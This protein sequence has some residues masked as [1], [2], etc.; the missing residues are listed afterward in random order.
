MLMSV[1]VGSD[2]HEYPDP[3]V[4]LPSLATPTNKKTNSAQRCMGKRRSREEQRGS[5]MPD[6]FLHGEDGAAVGINE[7]GVVAPCP[8]SPS[9][10]LP[11]Q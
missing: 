9:P 10:S 4:K 7:D 8:P 2:T 5:S 3:R 1:P 6:R 11:P